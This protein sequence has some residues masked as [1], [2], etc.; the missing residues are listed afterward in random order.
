M[1]HYTRRRFLQDSLLA[2]ATAAATASPAGFALAEPGASK[3][4]A[5]SPNEKLGIAMLGVRGQGHN[6]VAEYLRRK[7]VEILY[8]CDPDS[9]VGGQWADV[10]A[11][12]QK[13]KPRLVADFRQALDDAAVDFVSI[14]T[15]NYWHALA[16]IWAIQAGKDV[17]VEKPV[18]HNVSEGRRIVE[19][20]RKHG[21]I[22]QTGTQCRSMSGTRQAIRWI[23]E[24]NIGEVKLA[25]GL[26]YKQRKPLGSKG[27]YEVPKCV[28]Y[29]I[30]LGPAPMAPLTRPNLHYDWHWQTPYGN[31]DLG[32]QGIH[33]M[34]LARYGLNVNQLSDRVTSYG[35]RLGEGWDKDAGDTANCQIVVHE[36]GEKTLAFE[37]RNLRTDPFKHARVGVI[38]YGSDGCLV[39]NSYTGGMV[40]DN[41]LKVVKKFRGGQYADHFDNFIKAIR[42]RNHEDLHADILDGHLSSALCHTGNISWQLGKQ[43]PLADVKRWADN[44]Q[45]NET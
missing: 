33:Q 44:Y 30:Y 9:E 4:Q 34:D 20:A 31:G 15:P 42:S 21:R 18:S 24:G 3:N 27:I 13:R 28:D 22:C 2:A 45:S 14:A 35:G 8:V 39:L 10:I 6:H 38:F 19:A 23:H 32:N 12:K 29:N 16:A 7:D 36:F 5:G 41:D 43:V 25:R 37:V 11:K 40:F 26:C 17:Y 1:A